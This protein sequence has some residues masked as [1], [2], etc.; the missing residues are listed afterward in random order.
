VAALAGAF[1]RAAL[2]IPSPLYNTLAAITLAAATL[3]VA[4]C[5]A[6]TV[7]GWLRTLRAPAPAVT[8]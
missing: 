4:V 8:T 3:I 2:A 7:A 5:V 6:G 1:E